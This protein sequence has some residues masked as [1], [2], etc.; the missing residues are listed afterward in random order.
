MTNIFPLEVELERGLIEIEVETFG[1]WE[2][3]G[4][5]AYE[6]W[7]QNCYDRG[8]NYF[9]IEEFNWDKT[10]FTIEEVLEIEKIIESKI[11][12]WEASIEPEDN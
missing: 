4:I 2:N 6:F 8:Q 1:D 5:G 11:E 3:D 9:V 12:D 7:G 10:G